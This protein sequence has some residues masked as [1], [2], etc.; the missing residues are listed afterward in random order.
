MPH[1]I[2]AIDVDVR[3]KKR[4]SVGIENFNNR[5]QIG[6]KFGLEKP[7]QYKKKVYRSN[8]NISGVHCTKSHR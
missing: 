5:Q 1:Y 3:E 2:G 4:E 8:V 6:E 7:C